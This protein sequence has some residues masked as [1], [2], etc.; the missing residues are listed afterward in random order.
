MGMARALRRVRFAPQAARQ[1]ITAK[2]QPPQRGRE[3]EIQEAG[4]I[5]QA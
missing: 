3:Q 5:D 2:A 4:K 1:P